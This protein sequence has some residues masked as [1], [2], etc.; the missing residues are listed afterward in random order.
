[1]TLVYYLTCHFFV[2]LLQNLETTVPCSFLPLPPS[3]SLSAGASLV[4]T[5]TYIYLANKEVPPSFARFLGAVKVAS[6][7]PLHPTVLKGGRREENGLLRSWRTVQ[8]GAGYRKGEGEGVRHGGF[9]RRGIKRE[10][11]EALEYWKGS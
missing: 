8:W 2:V 1:M 3:P 10:Y 9:T 5:H 4:G 11:S 7:P 6:P